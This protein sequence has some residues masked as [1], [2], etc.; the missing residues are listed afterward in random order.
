MAGQAPRGE[1]KRAAPLLSPVSKEQPAQVERVASADRCR[2]SLTP[3]ASSTSPP[4]ELQRQ[5]GKRQYAPAYRASLSSTACPQYNLITATHPFPG[6]CPCLL[7]PKTTR[8]SRVLPVSFRILVSEDS[9]PFAE[10]PHRL[11]M[12]HLLRGT[13]HNPSRKFVRVR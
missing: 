2:R 6:R 3:P 13:R 12:R 5:P 10:W 8:E 9:A 4:T 1:S 11:M 7:L